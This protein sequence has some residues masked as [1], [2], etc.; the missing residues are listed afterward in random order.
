VR[1]A[2][3]PKDTFMSISHD[4]VER[5]VRLLEASQFDE[6]HLEL[7]GLK[8]DLRRRGAAPTVSR[9]PA[10]ASAIAPAL[11]AAAPKA[12]P[13]VSAVPQSELTDVKAPML[14]TFFLSPK[15]GAEPFVRVGSQ[16]ETDTVIGIVEVMKLMNSVSAGVSGEVVE[17]V[18]PDAQLVE[19][20]Q[21]LIRVRP[22]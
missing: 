19:Y 17:I 21:V 6:L 16:V 11:P 1:A 18:A 2:A 10:S 13:P 20:D 22:L 4:D 3:F 7:E 15:P 5:I 14:G 8:L 12:Q 9:V